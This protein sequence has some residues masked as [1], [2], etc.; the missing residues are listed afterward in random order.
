MF[1]VPWLKRYLTSNQIILQKFWL[2]KIS[3]KINANAKRLR[4][5]QNQHAV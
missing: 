4:K 1:F 3:Q 2:H 5:F